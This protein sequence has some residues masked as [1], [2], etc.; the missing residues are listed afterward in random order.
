MEN[1]E[2]MSRIDLSLKR[3]GVR[4]YNYTNDYSQKGLYSPRTR[5][6]L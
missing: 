3:M 5:K 6:N 2:L 4:N 1:K